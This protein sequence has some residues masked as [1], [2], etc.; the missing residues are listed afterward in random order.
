MREMRKRKRTT[1][2][3]GERRAELRAQHR[4]TQQMLA[5]R[6]AYHQA[7]IEARERGEGG[8]APAS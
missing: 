8:Q 5:E 2:A 7:R 4:R 1:T 3:D 6:I